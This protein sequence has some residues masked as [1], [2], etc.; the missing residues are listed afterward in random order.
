MNQH[1][2]RESNGGEGEFGDVEA[3]SLAWSKRGYV[4]SKKETF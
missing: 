4:S 3:N 2:F 1:G